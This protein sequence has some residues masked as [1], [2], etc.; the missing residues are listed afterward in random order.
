MNEQ[1]SVL[2]VLVPV[3]NEEKTVLQLLRR[4][5]GL[6]AVLKE[7]I[8]VDDG[9]TDATAALVRELAACDGRIRFHQMPLN[10]GKTAAIQRALDM[11]TGDIIIVQDADLEYDPAEIPEV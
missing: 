4:V 9:S 7:I 11:A 1:Q 10:G 5:L 2:S 8:V 6:G 3:F